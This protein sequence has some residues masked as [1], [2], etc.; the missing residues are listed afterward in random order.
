MKRTKNIDCDGLKVGHHGS[1]T[2]SEQSFLD[3]YTFEYAMISCGTH[4][5]HKHPRQATLDRMKDMEVYRTDKN[6]TIVLSIDK[7]GNIEFKS[8]TKSTQNQN[9]I[10]NDVQMATQ[11]IASQNLSGLFFFVCSAI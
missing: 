2:S 3:A 7:N 10:G 4:K 5:G 11:S 9:H 6:G 8:E 1:E